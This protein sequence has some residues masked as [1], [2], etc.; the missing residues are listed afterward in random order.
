MSHDAA[1][2]HAVDATQLISNKEGRS[3]LQVQDLTAASVLVAAVAVVTAAASEI[4][5]WSA[6]AAARAGKG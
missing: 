1:S 5:A 3:C 4:C 2:S 6:A